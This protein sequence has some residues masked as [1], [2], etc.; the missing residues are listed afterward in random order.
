MGSWQLWG[1]KASEDPQS[2]GERLYWIRVRTADTGPS[3][4]ADK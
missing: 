3:Q 1:E 2:P 4:G